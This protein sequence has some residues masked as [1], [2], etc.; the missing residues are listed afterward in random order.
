MGRAVSRIVK[1]VAKLIGGATGGATGA[2]GITTG[3]AAQGANVDKS[4]FLANSEEQALQQE[5]KRRYLGDGPTVAQNQLIQANDRNISNLAASAASQTGNQ[6]LVARSLLNAQAGAQQQTANQSA[7]VRAQEMQGATQAYQQ[8]V[9]SQ[10]EGRGQAE[11]TAAGIS[12]ANAS[13]QN[14]VAGENASRTAGV[15]S[16]IGSALSDEEGKMKISDVTIGKKK[17]DEPEMVEVVGESTEPGKDGNTISG[18]RNVKAKS[19]F[20]DRLA[21]LKESAST[22]TNE[23]V[24]AGKNA[25][26]G[27]AGIGKA[28]AGMSDEN[29]KTDKKTVS[30]SKAG[31][32]LYEDFISK[33]KA[34]TFEYKDPSAPG[35]SE[36]RK[37]GVMAQDL[38]KSEIGKQMVF[39]TP[40]GKMVDFAKAIAPMLAI[41]SVQNKEIDNLKSALQMKSKKTK[42]E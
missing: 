25:A 32:G 27:I 2:L 19:T 15:F 14:R 26:A 3:A 39:D 35:A 20:K 38:E 1:P 6:A 4:A 41:Q 16:G 28:I 10:R 12:G 22:E 13:M 11:M 5:L 17:T 40:G 21:K 23:E 24:Q 18:E 9:Q 37:L 33:I 7:Q 31:K 29:E 36:G 42:K 8:G 30:Q 34:K